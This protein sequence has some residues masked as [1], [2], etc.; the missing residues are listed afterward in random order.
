MARTGTSSLRIGLLLPFWD[1]EEQWGKWKRG[2]GNNNFNLGMAYIA[3]MLRQHGYP[4]KVCDPQFLPGGRQDLEQ[5]LRQQR[6]DLIGIACFTPTVTQAF[7][8]SRFCKSVWPGAKIVL[9]GGHPTIMPATVLEECA[10]VDFAISHEGEITMLDLA[11]ALEREMAGET[12][13]WSAISGLTWRSGDQVTVNA[14]RPFIADLDTL[15]RPAYELFPL[16]HYRLQ[17]TAYKRLPT[18]T[19][20]VSRGCPYR[21]TFCCGYRMLGR[22]MRYRSVPKVLEDMAYLIDQHGARGFMFQDTSMPCSRR[23]MTE[24]CEALLVQGLDVT[25]MCYSRA[26]H[27][28]R[29]LLVLMKKAGCYGISFGVESANQKSLDLIK[30]GMTVEQN[31][32]AVRTALD[33]GLY[34]TATYILGLPGETEADAR[35]TIALARR[36]ATHIAHFF[37]PLP[38]P[39]TEM[40]NQCEA[41]G[42][43]REDYDWGDFSMTNYQRMVYVN[44]LIGEDKMLNLQRMAVLR[45]YTHP[46]VI[47]RNLSTIDS[48]T[49]VKKY[50]NAALSISGYLF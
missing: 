11:G 5:Y 35:R 42:G 6:F 2:A 39:D 37:L 30:K 14:V 49:D 36:L 13:D 41:D 43:L 17:P 25:W 34:V 33:L 12:I 4:V 46:K 26:D 19:M 44:P 29:E 47:L 21:C 27:V 18:Y 7:A 20:L 38:Y 24:F 28:D 15:P 45:Y 10:S 3:G 32:E 48:M 22:K 1:R 16:N 9:G 31:I 50:L 23:W 8:M 40:M